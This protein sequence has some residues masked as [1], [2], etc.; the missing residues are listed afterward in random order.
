[1]GLTFRSTTYVASIMHSEYLTVRASE[2]QDED[3]WLNLWLLFNIAFSAALLAISISLLNQAKLI[4]NKPLPP[5]SPVREDGA[6]HYINKR[7]KPNKIFQSPPSD[8]VDEAWHGWLEEHD[9]MILIPDEKAEEEELPVSTPLYLD[10]GYSAYGLGVYH[11]MHC[12]ARIRK[13]FYP[14]RFYP[15]E[16]AESIES[17]LNV[18]RQ[19]LL[20]YGDTSLVYWW[21]ENYTFIDEAGVRQYTNNYLNMTPKER[22]K[23][24]FVMWNT[25]V[26]CRDID[27]INSWA[28][29]HSADPDKHGG[30]MVD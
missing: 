3:F 20:C 21:N 10:P 19:A 2:N 27:A 22:A 8:E 18:I 13:S 30:Q 1:M 5:Y 24:S 7:Y 9:K 25:Q 17:H 11:Q 26:Q 23:G 6:E 12:L 15:N 28:K 4:S 14:N 29:A 16:T